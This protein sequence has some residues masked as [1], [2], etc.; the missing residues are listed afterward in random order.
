MTQSL[1][2]IGGSIKEDVEDFRVTEVPLYPFSGAGEHLLVYVEKKGLGTLEVIRL[3][4]RQWGLRDKE[5]GYAGLKDRQGVTRQWFSL[6]AS[7]VDEG[8]LG[9]VETDQIRILDVARHTNKL[10]PGHLRGN[11]FLI[12]VR[13]VVARALSRAQEKLK[14]LEAHGV[15]NYYHH[16]RWGTRGKNVEEGLVLLRE[17]KRRGPPYKA[18][19]LISS[20]SAW[21]FNSYLDWRMDQGLFSYTL[22]GDIAKKRDTGGLF[23]VERPQEEDPRLKGREIDITGPLYGYKL[24][25]A[26][27]IPGDKEKAILEEAGLTL[28]GFKPFKSPGTRRPLRF[29]LQDIHVDQEGSNLVFSFFL[30]GGSYATVFLEEIMNPS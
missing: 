19:L 17:G 29:F 26:Q 15:P 11:Q 5:I 3:I 21:L 30:L 1:P 28:A 12:V 6:P 9:G 16:Q 20:V 18:R 7:K 25:V 27:G 22:Q 24:W 23:L 13:D 4:C 2:G 8:K 10:R 14:L